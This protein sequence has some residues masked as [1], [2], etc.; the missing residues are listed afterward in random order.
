MIEDPID[1]V[2]PVDAGG[3]SRVQQLLAAVMTVSSDLELE[4]VLDRITQTAV[5]LVDCKYAALGVLGQDYHDRLADSK[6]SSLVEFVTTGISDGQREEIGRPP[7]GE[8]ILG[9]LV[10]DP[11]PIRLDDLAKHPAS[12]GFP[13]NHPPMRSFLG[14]PVRVRGRV[15]GNLYLTQKAEGSFT[16]ADED[17]VITLATAAGVAIDNAR[18]YGD[19]RRAEERERARA[20]I[21]RALLADED[22]S[23]VLALV[24]KWARRISHAD[25]A[26]IG[27]EDRYGT[28]IIEI[29]DGSRTIGP[30]GAPLPLPEPSLLIPLGHRS[31]SA[32]LCVANA[33]SGRRFDRQVI[34]QLK[35]FADQAVIALELAEARHDA[36]RIGIFEDRDRIARDLHDSVIQR[37]FAAGLALE[38]VS[39]QIPDEQVNAKIHSISDDLDLTIRDIRSTIYSLQT[40]QRDGSIGLRAR[41]IGLTDELSAILGFSVK[42]RIDGLIDAGIPADAQDD[43]I[44]VVR[45][46]LT[47]I[48]KHAD[49]TRAEIVVEN[50][51]VQICI[52]VHD[53][54]CG[55]ASDPGPAADQ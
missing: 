7:H 44:A 22:S 29:A 1:P 6:E 11:R 23:E 4:V 14:V 52:Y 42:V 33:P 27:F 31:P 41:V 47:N 30:L 20:E 37:I 17:L 21:S 46:S 16:K 9:L 25:V 48:A 10:S 18:L 13:A 34:G 38:A 45:E 32:A 24:A 12:V 36:E 26:A 49:A 19:A 8:G 53:D 39:R 50:D 51:G 15:F 3:D 5:E 54:G 55:V 43:L 2:E 28:Q 40:L 35:A